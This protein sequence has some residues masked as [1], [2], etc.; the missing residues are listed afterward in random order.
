MRV[1]A[2][3][4]RHKERKDRRDRCRAEKR[5]RKKNAD[6]HQP[7]KNLIITSLSETTV[8]TGIVERS[9]DYTDTSDSSVDSS[10][11]GVKNLKIS[12]DS[13]DDNS[14][15][16]QE[17]FKIPTPPT[18]RGKHCEKGRRNEDRAGPSRDRRALAD[19][20]DQA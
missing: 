17:R 5:Q 15:S 3:R 13:M 7:S 20:F 6:K 11:K 1:K 10:R 14:F 12:D 19:D 18:N 9:S 8:Y 16:E 2:K 4:R